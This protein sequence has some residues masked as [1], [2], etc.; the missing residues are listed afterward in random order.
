MP[1]LP[2]ASVS[3]PNQV[4]S[5]GQ[6]PYVNQMNFGQLIGRVTS[7]NPDAT[8]ISGQWINDAV[9]KIYDRKTWYS[10]L[11]KGQ[12][13]CPAAYTRGSAIAVSGSSTVQ[14]ANG[15]QWTQDL[16]GRQFRIGYNNP[17]YTIIGVDEGAQTL[18]L[19]MPWGSRDVTG[20]YFIVQYY[21]NIGPNIKYIKT[22]VNMIQACKMRLRLTQ[23]YLNTID[24]W[25]QSG[26]VFPW[27]AAPMPTAMDGSYLIEL[28]PVSWIQQ[29]LP[30][31]AYVQPPNLIND[32]DVLPPYIRGDIVVKDAIAEALLWRGPKKNPYYDMANAQRLKGE[33]ENELLQMAN[34]DEN[35]YRTQVTFPGEEFPDFTPGGAM[36]DAM[37]ASMAGGEYGY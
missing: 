8:A 15:T 5:N 18:Q 17:I 37:H 19:E 33:F 26:G 30:F 1:I 2:Q 7:A 31:Q 23:D 22:M 35:L 29:A 6:N 13:L 32:S 11:V 4:L 24:P 27:G 28:Y 9:R 14:G 16:V 12:V 10:L 36:W 34:A 25:R 20:G 3:I 21:Y